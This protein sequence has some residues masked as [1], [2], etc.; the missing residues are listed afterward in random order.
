MDSVRFGQNRSVFRTH[1]FSALLV[2]VFLFSLSI[3]VPA[4]AGVVDSVRSTYAS[5]VL[6]FTSLFFREA[7]TTTLSVTVVPPDTPEREREREGSSAASPA[8]TL[9]ETSVPVAQTQQKSKDDT[10]TDKHFIT[11]EKLPAAR[12][13]LSVPEDYVS[14]SELHAELAAL[15]ERFDNIQLPPPSQEATYQNVG[16]IGAIALAG[17]VESLTDLTVHSG[18]FFGGTIDGAQITN[19]TFTGGAGAFSSLTATRADNALDTDNLFSVA[20]GNGISNKNYL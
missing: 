8:L 5:T 18:S 9:S 15:A 6:W 17:R 16:I 1:V 4:Q 19:S 13:A 10:F 2:F 14:R 20:A 11:T 3:P 7:D 12:S